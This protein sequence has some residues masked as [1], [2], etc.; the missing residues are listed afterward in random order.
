MA[1]KK[2]LSTILAIQSDVFFF[3]EVLIQKTKWKNPYSRGSTCKPLKVGPP[4]TG[5]YGIRKYYLVYGAL[6][7]S[8]DLVL[9]SQVQP[10]LC[11]PY[12]RK[13]ARKLSCPNILCYTSFFSI[14]AN[15]GQFA[16]SWGLGHLI[17][18]FTYFIKEEWKVNT[19]LK[20]LQ[21]EEKCR[22][23]TCTITK[24]SRHQQLSKWL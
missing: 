1:G 8:S 11:D 10:I 3:I 20:H 16:P 13:L 22:K 17:I 19:L 9:T 23:K 18:I 6:H 15:S 5:S 14:W 12:P 21:L 4:D 2:Q 24:A 7:Y